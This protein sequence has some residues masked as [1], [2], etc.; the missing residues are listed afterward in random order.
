MLTMTTSNVMEKFTLYRGAKIHY[1]DSGKGSAVVFLHGFLEEHAM[2]DFFVAELSKK[3]RVFAFDLLGDGQTENIG[4]VHTMEDQ[5]EMICFVLHETKIRK[6]N[7]VG[8]SEGGRSAVA[9]A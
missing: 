9:V 4:Y 5:A 7:T 8:Q 2:W 6:A 1:T 3:H